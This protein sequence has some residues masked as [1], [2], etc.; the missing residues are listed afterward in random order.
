MSWLQFNMLGI[1]LA[2]AAAWIFGAL[3]YGPLGNAWL[4]AQG[5]TMAQMKAEQAEKSTAAKVFPF[6]LSFVAELVMAWVIYGLLTHMNFFSIRGGIISGV[7]CWLGFVVT[8]IAVNNAYSGRKPA[9]TAIDAGHWLGTLI[10]IGGI[11]GWAG[12]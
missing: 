9:L 8:T 2:A 3:Y 1:L 10:I 4:K 6:V 11:V 7:F 5:R 12:P